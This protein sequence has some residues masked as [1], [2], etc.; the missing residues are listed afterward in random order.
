MKEQILTPEQIEAYNV[1]HRAI[2]EALCQRD[3]QKVAASIEQHL[4]KA[5]QDLIGA[6]SA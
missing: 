6:K 3:S 2:Y 4:E 5:R 1:Q